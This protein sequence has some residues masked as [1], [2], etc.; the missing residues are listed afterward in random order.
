[1][2]EQKKVVIK[3]VDQRLISQHSARPIEISEDLA[4]KY[5]E[6]GWAKILST[7]PDA[8]PDLTDVE[9]DELK[10]KYQKDSVKYCLE[11][12]WLDKV[13]FVTGG[14]IPLSLRKYGDACGFIIS[15]TSPVNFS[16]GKLCLNE[17]I[18]LSSNLDGFSDIQKLKLNVVLF[19]RGIPFSYYIEDHLVDNEQIRHY[20]MRAEVLFF[21]HEDYIEGA[22]EMMGEI[23]EEKIFIVSDDASFWRKINS[24]EKKP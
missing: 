8:N 19:Q 21:T 9:I 15:Q 16:P 22:S 2:S 23:I 10:A 20:L 14:Q 17:L 18:I 7:L 4:Q 5:V 24:L 11:D 3:Y 12:K 6:R 1:M 13:G